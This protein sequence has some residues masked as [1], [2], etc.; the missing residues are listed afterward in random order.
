MPNN[1]KPDRP[2]GEFSE[3]ERATIRD[4]LIK[5]DDVFPYLASLVGMFKSAKTLAIA[6]GFFA[7]IAAGVRWAVSQGFFG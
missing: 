1:F 7:A 6:F 4:M 3:D 2:K 5:V